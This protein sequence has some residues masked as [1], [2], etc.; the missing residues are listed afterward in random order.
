MY[1]KLDYAG[2]NPASWPE[3]RTANGTYKD[4]VREMS[5]TNFANVEDEAKY[6]LDQ[7]EPAE[8]ESAMQDA[9]Y[10][11]SFAAQVLNSILS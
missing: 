11:Y 10:G 6:W 9:G 8:V 5:G 2:T 3:A 1:T 7:Y 4:M